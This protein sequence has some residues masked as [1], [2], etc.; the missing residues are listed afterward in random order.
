MD[1]YCQ[2]RIDPK[3]EPEAVASIMADLMKE[4]KIRA[5]GISEANEEYLC[6]ADAVC[7]VAAVENRCSIM[8]G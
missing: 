3:V 8:A 1:L 6:H 7:P 2:H 5:W 4:G